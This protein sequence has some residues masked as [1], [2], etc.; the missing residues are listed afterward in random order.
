MSRRGFAL[1]VILLA[2]AIGV[3]S[4]AVSHFVG[5]ASQAASEEGSGTALIV[6]RFELVDQDGRTVRGEDLRDKLQLVFFGFA[7][8]PDICP[9]TL[10]K[11]GAALKELG[12]D[13]D[14]L[15]PMLI[16]VDPERDTPPVLRST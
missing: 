12:A 4:L 14:A 3:L 8:C 2:V 13:A 10:T 1:I 7:T 15:R 11:I 5:D 6:S 9:T 16:T